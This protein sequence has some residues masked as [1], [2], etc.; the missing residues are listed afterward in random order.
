[1]S[2]KGYLLKVLGLSAV[3]R[4]AT[5]GLTVFSFPLM[6][7]ALGAASYGVVVYLMSVVLLFESFVDCGVSSA[8][9]KAIARTRV[10]HPEQLRHELARWMK[11][12][13]MAA[14]AGLALA[15]IGGYYL[16][17]RGS[18]G[19]AVSV[20]LFSIIVLTAWVAIGSSFIRATLNSLLQFKHLAVIDVTES[21]TRSAGYLFVAFVMPTMTALVV[22]GLLTALCSVALG[23]PLTLRALR[24]Y[25]GNANTVGSPPG[26]P[27]K[28]ID[29]AMIMESLQFL[30][31]RFATRAF[32][33][34]PL[35]IIGQTV[36][37]EVVG[38]VG[39][40]SRL[41][42][43][44]SFPF[45]VIANALMVK[46][47]EIKAGGASALRDYWGV[48]ARICV[49]AL[50]ASGGVLLLSGEIARAVVP[51]SPHGAVL[52]A[53][54]S[55]L[56]LARCVSDL[57]APAS[58]Y[59]GALGRRVRFLGVCSVLQLPL[60]WL[61]AVSYGDLG[62]VAAVVAAY[63]LMILG[64]AY[65]AKR[66]F[67]GSQPYRPPND[68]LLAA[69]LTIAMLVCAVLVASVCARSA[70]LMSLRINPAFISTGFYVAVLLLVFL[71]IP[72]LNRLY[73][74]LRF[75]ELRQ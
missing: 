23:I 61:G 73:P 17:T 10:E 51:K 43:M 58:D 53:I 37:A 33:S 30:G 39:A 68:V 3:P 54:M 59:V 60:I 63:A 41:V 26:V 34:L 16:A 52:F 11:L 29:R 55:V 40:F 7:R 9:G 14:S 57:L 6:V 74:T 22:A 62:A 28:T 49:L 44:M 42:E 46:I 1:M 71:G 36:G 50:V 2:E 8:T 56:F 48:I 31:L 27:H 20:P 19:G 18:S 32:Q 47:F 75:L 24:R 4:I 25:S 15:A 12:Q 70:W 5:F 69:A 67:F 65:I 45:T 72:P 38:I 13:L 66:A 64:Y 21:L 35:V